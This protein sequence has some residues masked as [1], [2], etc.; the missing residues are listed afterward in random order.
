MYRLKNIT[1]IIVAFSFILAGCSQTSEDMATTVESQVAF[2]VKSTIESLPS[3]TAAHT[4]TPYP[5]L[6][7][8]ATYTPYP[9]FTPQPTFTPPA[10]YTP[11]PTLTPT[12]ENT[13]TAV[14]TTAPRIQATAVVPTAGLP[15]AAPVSNLPIL[16]E[17]FTTTLA[18]MGNYRY[19]A[20]RPDGFRWAPVNCQENVSIY[21]RITSPFSLDVSSDDPVVQN[22]YAVYQAGIS[23][24]AELTKPWTDGC[25]EAL[26]RG[27]ETITMDN[28]QRNT[29]FSIIG[30]VESMLNSAYD[31]LKQLSE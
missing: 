27:E 6:T 12:P 26:A 7:P 14:P 9:T 31:Q 2:A 18:D 10:T 1:L 3:A 28:N 30:G 22:A 21:D 16:K 11:Y 5:S 13:A 29:L 17:K 24:F 20:V 15:T 25:R 19:S 4:Q 8:L 23:Q